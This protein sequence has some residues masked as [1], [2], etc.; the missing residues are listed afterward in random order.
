MLKAK[1]RVWEIG[2]C[3]CIHALS[4]QHAGNSVRSPPCLLLSGLCFF[5]SCFA[6]RGQREGSCRGHVGAGVQ[7]P[8][9]APALC[10][11][12]A[13]G[14]RNASPPAASVPAAQRCCAG[15]QG[16]AAVQGGGVGGSLF[17]CQGERRAKASGTESNPYL[18]DKAA[19]SAHFVTATC[20]CTNHME[21]PSQTGEFI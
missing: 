6:A 1:I 12:S 13:L 2:H 16:Q 9:G 19:H 17:S 18:K 11:W 8:P 4:A 20:L 15:E 5:S 3:W 14:F 10:Y 21:Q 7:A